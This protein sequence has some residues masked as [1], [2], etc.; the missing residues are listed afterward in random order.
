MTSSFTVHA[1][2]GYEQLMGRWSRRLAPKFIDFVGLA[3]GEKILD[4][5]CGTGSLTFELAKSRDLAEIQAIDFSA[6][7]VAAAKE[8]NTDRRITIEQADATALPFEDNAFDRA[9]ALLVLHFV[10]ETG[11]A[12]A[13]MRRVTRPGGVVAAV[14]WDHL[15]G[16][17]A[18]RMM[19]D[20]VAALSESGRQMRNR[21]CFQPMMQP[22]EMKRTFVEQGLTDVTE[23]ELMIRMDYQ[24]FDDYWAP[25]AAG[26]GP[27]GKYMTTLDAAERTRTEAAVR[28]AYEAGRA[29]GP[30]SF[31]NVAW[32]CRGIVR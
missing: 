29:D 18:M 30:R 20:T 21:Y 27:L 22:G 1:A 5:G 32:A 19:I 16:M 28:D 24:N 7:F 17:P 11:K 12:V 9:L 23:T 6:V 15:G 3:G 4:V 2:S 8:R 31:A 13:E 25:I 26:E 10:P 14:V